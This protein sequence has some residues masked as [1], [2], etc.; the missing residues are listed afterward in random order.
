MLREDIVIDH[1][2]NPIEDLE[3]SD[4]DFITKLILLHYLLSG[5]WYYLKFRLVLIDESLE[6][7]CR[8]PVIGL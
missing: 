1:Y 6:K 2:V 5:V 7:D 8:I 3:E 4:Y